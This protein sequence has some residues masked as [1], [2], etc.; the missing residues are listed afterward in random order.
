[1]LNTQNILANTADP[2]VCSKPKFYNLF[3]YYT[4]CLCVIIFLLTVYTRHINESTSVVLCVPDQQGSRITIPSIQ[5]R[6][7]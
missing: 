3:L 4:T 5:Y 7:Q 2:V 6:K 1:M